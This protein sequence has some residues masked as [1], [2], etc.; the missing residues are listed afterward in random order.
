MLIFKSLKSSGEEILANIT[1]FTST[2]YIMI[3]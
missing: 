2:F 3:S 1:F